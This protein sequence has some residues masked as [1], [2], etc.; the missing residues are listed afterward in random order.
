MK[1]VLHSVR[2][3]MLKK[4][5]LKM[6]QIPN[7]STLRS[8]FI[9]CVVRN[10]MHF[11]SFSLSANLRISLKLKV[12]PKFI[13]SRLMSSSSLTFLADREKIRLRSNSENTKSNGVISAR[14]EKQRYRS[15][16]RKDIFLNTHS[17][18]YILFSG[19]S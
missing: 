3:G 4:T 1:L 10:V 9:V 13:I 17:L 12:C 16:T 14:T 5:N 6:W 7:Q 15:K 18:N 8:I 2:G 11:V 19:W